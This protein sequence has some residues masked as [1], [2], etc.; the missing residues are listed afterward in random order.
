MPGLARH[1]MLQALDHLVKAVVYEASCVWKG[2]QLGQLEA[3]CPLYMDVDSPERHYPCV[4]CPSP[5]AEC[6]LLS[7]Q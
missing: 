6:A 7:G 3:N 2:R 5:S 4:S 1:G